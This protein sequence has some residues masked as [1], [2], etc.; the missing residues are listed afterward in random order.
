MV[1]RF[2]GKD[3][4]VV[5]VVVV[6]VVGVVVVVVVANTRPDRRVSTLLRSETTSLSTSNSRWTVVP[7]AHLLCTPTPNL[8][9]SGMPHEIAVDQKSPL[10][11]AHDAWVTNRGGVDSHGN[12]GARLAH[13]RAVVKQSRFD[14]LS[15]RFDCVTN[16]QA[17]FGGLRCEERFAARA[18][19]I[20]VPAAPMLLLLACC[21]PARH[22]RLVRLFEQR[23]LVDFFPPWESAGTSLYTYRPT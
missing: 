1:F 8:R 20:H 13:K 9:M 7:H 16:T 2:T 5:A 23:C 11:G 3:H 4:V 14:V 21:S 10:H 6:V 17:G 12:K 19:D 22:T 18:R 15:T